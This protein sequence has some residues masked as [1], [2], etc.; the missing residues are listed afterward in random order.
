MSSIGKYVGKINIVDSNNNINTVSPIGTTL[1]GK[2]T[3][4][5]G[6]G[7]KI[8]KFDGD[9]FNSVT[10]NLTIKVKFAN[11]NTT[12][13]VSLKIV[14]INDE[15]TV[16]LD[17]VP[18]K[19]YDVADPEADQAAAQKSIPGFTPKSSWYAGE[20]VTFTYI[21]GSQGTNSYWYMSPKGGV[22]VQSQNVVTGI[23]TTNTTFALNGTTL[24][25]TTTS[26]TP[27]TVNINTLIS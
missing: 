4:D 11:T 17:S 14:S 22:D 10:D 6:T 21:Q 12:R 26:V 25:I 5:A 8:V 1:L 18:V 27:S 23:D 7:T 15:E 9:A 20:V 2:C 24:N 16:F 3:T 19:F 13:G